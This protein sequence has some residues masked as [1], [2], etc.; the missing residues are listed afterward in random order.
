[1]YSL[2]KEKAAKEVIVTVFLIKAMRSY[3]QKE[4]LL[5]FW[6]R[7]QADAVLIFS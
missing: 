6:C 4:L 3:R 5:R 1:V 7:E 2:S